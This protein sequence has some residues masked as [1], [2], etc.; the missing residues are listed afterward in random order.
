MKNASSPAPP[1]LSKRAAR[2][3]SE[4]ATLFC[5]IAKWS[6][7][8]SIVGAIT[9]ASTSLFLRVL[10]WA[11]GTA[12]LCGRSYLL[13]PLTLFATACLVRFLAPEA[14]GHG[15]EKVIEAVHKRM[16][17]IDLMVVPV[18][19]VATVITLATG[20][21]AGKEGPCAQIGSGLAS[22]F[23]DILRVNDVDRRKL[24]I[25][26]V[27]AG[28]AS[29][30]GTPVAGALFGV[31]VLFLGRILYDV[32]FPSFVAGIT[33]YHVS[34]LLGTHYLSMPLGA[35]PAVNETTIA[36]MVAMGLWCGLTAFIFIETIQGG[37]RLFDALKWRFTPLKAI[38]G[39]VL[40]ALAGLLV[41][42][43]YLGLGTE[44]VE[45]GLK[46]TVLPWSAVLWKTVTTSVTLG[47]G[48]SGGIIT[49]VFFVGVSAGNL[50]AQLFS[51]EHLQMFSAIGM[52][53]VLAAC[54]NTP[55]SA[56]VMAIELFG[57]AVSPYAA[58]ACMVSYVVVGH[59]SVYPSQVV[60]LLKSSSFSGET[61]STVGAMGEVALRPRPRMLSGLVFKK[62]RNSARKA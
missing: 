7:L 17:K 16:G 22:G 39:G 46:G 43:M 54:A 26:G 27:S 33:A 50:F 20:G 57:P 6:I 3:M 18:K 37:H 60:T 4:Q 19:L 51:P 11:T 36:Q 5:S 28:F 2:R 15:T 47:C 35:I 49:P 52:A 40:L 61:G 62:A 44:T 23:A 58:I 45:A 24:V 42:P 13:L 9:G 25:C 29:I 32:L 30:F 31:E 10:A 1:K 56:S 38:P 14:A 55:I 12:S 53:A 21:S 48:G 59:R 8:A 41:S 34:A